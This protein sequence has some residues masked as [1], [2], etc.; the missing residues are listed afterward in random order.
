MFIRCGVLVPV[1]GHHQ[2]Q[3]AWPA[4][5]NHNCG[6]NQYR[7]FFPV[8][9]W[10]FKYFPLSSG[11]PRLARSKRQD[12]SA[13]SRVACRGPMWCPGGLGPRE[14]ALS[15]VLPLTRSPGDRTACLA[16]TLCL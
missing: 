12:P 1:D 10:H 4:L 3:S 8:L 13:A 16:G 2:L 9:S 15:C 7:I 11:M 5:N 6:P 14:T